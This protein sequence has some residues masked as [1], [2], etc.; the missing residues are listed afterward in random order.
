MN[1]RSLG[2]LILNQGAAFYSLFTEGG[3]FRKTWGPTPAFF[4][5]CG[6]RLD[7]RR[8]EDVLAPEPCQLWMGR[9]A[10]VIAGHAQNLRERMEGRDWFI[11]MFPTADEEGTRCAA[12]VVRE[13]TAWTGGD[14]DL[15]HTV[16]DAIKAQEAE[17]LATSRFLHDSVGQN[18]TA[19]G[20][21]LDL[22]RMDLEAVSPEACHRL[23]E[24]QATIETVME[25]VRQFSYALNPST[26]ERTGLQ[27]ALDRLRSRALEQFNGSLHLDLDPDLR[28]EPRLASPL[29][30]IIQEAVDNAVR[31]AVCSSIEVEL[32][33]APRSLCLEVRDNGV[34]FDPAALLGDRR[35]LGL[36]RMRHAAADAGMDFCIVTGFGSGTIIRVT[37]P[38]AV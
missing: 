5:A 1:E 11:G 20:L 25:A 4:K 22:A 29:F 7:G 33:A 36:L 17:R 24:A 10:R 6:G 8:I 9:L 23:E 16:L 30:K 26:V 3:I 15:R 13:I 37:A 31:H 32:K 38:Q 34:G 19:I 2:D 12:L 27:P 21:Q 28:V 18:L 35:G 14:L